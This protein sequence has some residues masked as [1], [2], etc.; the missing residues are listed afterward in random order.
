MESESC[1]ESWKL[2]AYVR[3]EKQVRFYFELK[4]EQNGIDPHESP[5]DVS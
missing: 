3:I 5:S 1:A 2:C 4:S